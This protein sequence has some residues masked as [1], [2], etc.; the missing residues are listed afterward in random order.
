MPLNE[1]TNKMKPFGIILIILG[2]LGGLQSASWMFGYLDLVEQD[3]PFASI[4]L[5]AS[6]AGGAVAA[7]LIGGG[8]A[9][10]N[11]ANKNKNEINWN[12]LTDEQKLVKQQQILEASEAQAAL[13]KQKQE[14]WA[15]Q[16][17]WQR[18]K[19]MWIAFMGIA[20]IPVIA[21]ISL[22]FA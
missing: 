15:K 12:A 11:S 19:A 21:G 13:Q 17:A 5:L 7:G 18:Y 2:S 16:N 10:V 6:L 20:V 1:G 9:M 14:E 3:N 4:L 22:I 8:I